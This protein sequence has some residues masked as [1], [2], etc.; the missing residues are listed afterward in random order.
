MKNILVNEILCKKKV[1][2]KKASFDQFYLRILL[3]SK[4]SF[5]K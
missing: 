1:S 4:R 3:A 2:N 5:K